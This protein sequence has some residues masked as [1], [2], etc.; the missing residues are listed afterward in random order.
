MLA[1]HLKK[2]YIRHSVSSSDPHNYLAANALHKQPID[3]VAEHIVSI[4]R[5]KIQE[6]RTEQPS[7]HIILIGFNAGAALALQIALA[8]NVNSIVCMGFAYNTVN[9]VRGAPDDHILD[10]TTPIMFVI[11]QNSARSR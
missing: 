4:S 7:R 5:A 11:G 9:G 2:N 10:I 3:Q 6:L 1:V 8:E